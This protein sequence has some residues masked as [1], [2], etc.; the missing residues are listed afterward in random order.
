MLATTAGCSGAKE[1]APTPATT[2]AAGGS[3][4]PPLFRAP[5]E[6]TDGDGVAD[7][8]DRCPDA[9]AHA[10][11]WR[12]QPGCPAPRVCLMIIPRREI[13]ILEKI[14]FAPGST[15]LSVESAPSLDALAA[16]Y[17][18][19]PDLMSD[20]EGRCA[21]NEPRALAKQ[22]AEK[23]KAAL[24]ARGADAAQL[25]VIEAPPCDGQERTDRRVG[26]PNV[27]QR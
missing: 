21:L 22:R 27:R 17:K 10:N 18:E 8:H 5:P 26:F 20:V 15:A 13:A 25:A 19:N 2:A 14:V 11:E 16:F 23:V 24:V 12:D 9:F 4:E 6:D 3:A 7:M 1:A